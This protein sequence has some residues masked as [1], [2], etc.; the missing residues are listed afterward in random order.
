[1]KENRIHI[2]YGFHVNCYHSYRGDTN[3]NLGFGS[4]IRIIRKILDVLTDFASS[5]KFYLE[6]NVYHND[7]IAM[8]GYEEVPYWQGEGKDGAFDFAESSK[9]TIKNAAIYADE[10]SGDPIEISQTGV[11]AF[12]RDEDMVKAYFGELYSWEVANVRE[13]AT[14]HG[15]QAETGYAVE[16]HANGWVFYIADET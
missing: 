15:E 11:I 5:S 2:A 4:D 8:K 14:N 16:P 13:R 12:L 9:I 7:L 1:M 10:V 6:S 3:D